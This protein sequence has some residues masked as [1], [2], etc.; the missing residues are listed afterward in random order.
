[1]WDFIYPTHT[2]LP[3]TGLSRPGS[4]SMSPA[5]KIRQRCALETQ[6]RYMRILSCLPPLK[7]TKIKQTGQPLM[8][9]R[10]MCTLWRN[11]KRLGFFFFFSTK[12]IPSSQRSENLFVGLLR[13]S[14]H[15]K[16]ALSCS[17]TL[18]PDTQKGGK[19]STEEY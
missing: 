2:L 7:M 11:I 17:A 6:A 4:P 10:L 19:N 16:E 15:W 5:I 9:N 14:N 18:Q 8:Y 13:P 1:M 12:Y 3:K